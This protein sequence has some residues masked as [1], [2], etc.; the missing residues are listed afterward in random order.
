MNIKRA[1]QAAD[2][3]ASHIENPTDIKRVLTCLALAL[4]EKAAL[5]ELKDTVPDEDVREKT[6]R[7]V[8][9]ITGKLEIFIDET[10]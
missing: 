2:D 10:C 7:A 4:G 9:F 3:L 8:N 1:Q 6:I 5:I